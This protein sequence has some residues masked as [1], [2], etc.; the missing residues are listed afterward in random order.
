MKNL[1]TIG[2]FFLLLTQSL[3][4]FSQHLITDSQAREDVLLK[5]S[6]RKALFEKQIPD[7]FIGTDTIANSDL[8]EAVQF[9]IAY[10]PLSDL[11]NLDA[12]YFRTQAEFALKTKYIFSWGQNI[13]SEV[14]LHFVLPYRINNENP[15]MARQVFQ[16][17][18][19]ERVIDLS[20]YDA[21]LEVN[22]WCH[23]KVNYKSTGFRTSS[24]LATVKTAYGRCGE[25]S[26]FTVAAMRSVGIPARQVYTPRWAHSDDNHAWVEVWIDGKWC[27]L[28]ACE[29]LPELNMGWFA[30]P[31]T[32]AIMMHTNTF[33]Q[34]R[35]SEKTLVKKELFSKLNLLSNYA[36]VKTAT[37]KVV[38]EKGIALE[39]ISVDF[40]VY[41]YAE[42]YPFAR[43]KS[44]EEGLCSI[45]TGFGDLLI[46]ISDSSSFTWKKYP[47]KLIDTLQVILSQK[48]DLCKEEKNS[49]FYD[50][51]FI[52]PHAG[53]IIVPES[54][55]EKENKRRLK[56]EDSI[57]TAYVNTFPDSLTLAEKYTSDSHSEEIISFII[58]SRGNYQAISAF[59]DEALKLDK[60][61]KA[62]EILSQISKKDLRDTPTEILINHILYAESFPCNN[63]S[64]DLIFVSYVLN[65]RIGY[66]K[67]SP[68][69][70]T[71]QSV[72]SEKQIKIF[73]KNPE[74]LS[75]W[76][77]ETIEIDNKSNYYRTPLF[78]EG[79]MKLKQADVYSRNVCFV[80]TCRSLGIPARLEPATNIPQYFENE[81]INAFP[82]KHKIQE[83]KGF[84]ILNNNVKTTPKYYTHFTLA[85]LKNARFHSLD[86]EY[87]DNLKEFPCTLSLNPGTYR[88]MTGNRQ[89]DASVFT[90][91]VFFEIKAGKTIEKNILL[92]EADEKL[93]AYF[94]M[95]L[96]YKTLKDYKSAEYISP[97]SL[98]EEKGL[99]LA[100][101]DPRTEPGKH[102]LL[103]L[104][105]SASEF[106]NWQG[107][108]ALVQAQ[109]MHEE[110]SPVNSWK[111]L[112]KN[113]EWLLDEKGNLEKELKTLIQEDLELPVIL[114]LNK[115]KEVY[116]KASGYQINTA[117]MLLK[118]IRKLENNE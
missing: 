54:S 63:C 76:F 31:A 52:P 2:F 96:A 59:Y 28:G 100:L 41:N 101:I 111:N 55:K 13:P 39:N 81:W 22:H 26:T 47:A 65:P 16:K 20:I 73:R 70:Q 102:F 115:D 80:A 91:W 64:S 42:F 45:E 36:P 34:Y 77:V 43:L 106:N 118:I 32:R 72:F 117:Q 56:E 49:F 94:K 109:I 90:R 38:N 113:T 74:K 4:V 105:Q 17:E 19:Q 71:L 60:S 5:Y 108:I 23:E 58:E 21:V 3:F 86:Y 85:I 8:Q 97:V 44:N 33:G 99:V 82:E 93:E 61:D 62:I 110:E 95:D 12:N 83:E 50:M 35:G 9:L 87:D 69:R 48:I 46:W 116:F 25:E 68:W 57:R 14:F 75:E 112:P 103:E 10:A 53:K 51:H 88:L 79:T 37:V 78:P 7:V 6:Q 66:E 40:M 30:V 11:A 92:S 24:P 29:P 67:L 84:L 27:F 89:N 107:K 98:I 104:Q 114:Y 1:I 15:D 18:L